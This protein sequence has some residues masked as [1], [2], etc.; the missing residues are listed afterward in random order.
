MLIDHLNARIIKDK[1]PIV[2]GLDPRWDLIPEAIKHENLKA[3]GETFKA[4]AESILHFNKGIIDA[5]MESAFVFKPQIAFY[6]QYGIEGIEAYYKTCQYVKEVG[7]IVIG[8]I[9]RGDIGSTSEAY[10]IAH[11]GETTIG[12]R[13]LKAFDSD[14]VT[15]NPYLGSDCIA[16]FLNQCQTHDKGVFVLVKTSNPSS[17]ELQ[18]LFVGNTR[19]YERIADWVHGWSIKT[20]GNSGYSSVGAVVGAT[21]P[22][23]LKRLREKMPNSIFLVPGYG[24]QGGG[25]KDVV[26]AFDSNG[27]GA[28]INNSRGILY[29]YRKT[30]ENYQIAAKKAANEMKAS[31]VLELERVAK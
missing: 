4:V 27:L 10:A 16:P 26:E 11:L 8:D 15:I 28:L 9:K 12:N 19:I 22:E 5:V 29:A 20:T 13:S 23:E 14:F 6:E 25:A 2:V 31:I 7:G 30:G 24:A 17:G 1:S 3:Y 21:Y 18:D